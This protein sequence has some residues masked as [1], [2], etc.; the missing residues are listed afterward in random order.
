[1]MS[2]R[3]HGKQPAGGGLPWVEVSMSFEIERKCLVRG[4]GWQHL[5]ANSCSIRQAYLTLG[6]KASVRVRICDNRTATLTVKSRPADCVGWS[7]NIPFRSWKPR[8]SCRSGRAQSSR[9]CAI[10]SP[11][12]NSPGRSTCSR[13]RTPAWSLPK[14]NCAM[15]G[16]TWRCRHGS[17]RKSPDRRSTTTASWCRARFAH[18]LKAIQKCRWAGGPERLRPL[19]RTG[20][21]ERLLSAHLFRIAGRR[22]L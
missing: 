11:G 2:S 8:P 12:T 9:R 4:D 7:S 19:A 16:S 17:A 20:V 5:A 6:G 18:G 13:A 15:K 14:S 3:R 1:M 22:R 21:G 10:G